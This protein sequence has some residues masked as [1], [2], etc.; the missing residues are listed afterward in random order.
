MCTF[1]YFLLKSAITFSSCFWPVDEVQTPSNE[2]EPE[3][4]PGV[5]PPVAVV[6]VVLF[7]EPPPHP[8]ATPASERTS[9]VTPIPRRKRFFTIAFLSW[10]L[11]RRFRARSPGRRSGGHESRR[12][13]LPLAPDGHVSV[14][15]NGPR[16]RPCRCRPREAVR[17]R[18][19]RRRPGRAR[20]RHPSRPA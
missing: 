1:G 16:A 12:R 20:G 19:R 2:I 14:P 3:T 4:F 11:R 8:A 9:A 13:P 5:P 18:A 15:R 6:V 7:F 10:R 17:P